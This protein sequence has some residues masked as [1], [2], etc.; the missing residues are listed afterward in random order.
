[1]A[2]LISNFR[3]GVNVVFLLWVI[4]WLLNCMCRCFG[5]PC[6]IFT[7][8]VILPVYMTYEDGTDTA[9][10]TSAHKIETPRNHPK[11]RI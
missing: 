4:P 3:E 8:R 11:E 9:S 5:T 2:F 7:G 1:M 10:E 6:S